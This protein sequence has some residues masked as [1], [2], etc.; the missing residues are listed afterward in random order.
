VA[1][2]VLVVLLDVYVPYAPY[3]LS[4]VCVHDW[5][6]I[7]SSSRGSDYGSVYLVRR[8]RKYIEDFVN[9]KQNNVWC[10]YLSSL[11]FFFFLL[12]LFGSDYPAKGSYL[13]PAINIYWIYIQILS[14]CRD[15]SGSSFAPSQYIRIL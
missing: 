2:D 6:E 4:Y 9:L 12:S 8:Q 11:C 10:S 3:V 13:R 7:V 14:L 15:G 1:I 5:N